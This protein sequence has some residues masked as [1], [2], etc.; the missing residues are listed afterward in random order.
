MQR[1]AHQ[2][3]IDDAKVYGISAAIIRRYIIETARK[4]PGRWAYLS[5]DDIHREH[6]YMS[7]T[8]VK[9][10]LEKLVYRCVII[11]DPSLPPQNDRDR[12]WY[13]PKETF[14]VSVSERDD[15]GKVLSPEPAGMLMP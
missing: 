12:R 8:R 4:N 9:K 10:A 1:T 14:I 13:Q 7:L 15:A 2:F 3:S 11:R 5:A 6:S